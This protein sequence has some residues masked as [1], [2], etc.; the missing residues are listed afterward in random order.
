MATSPDSSGKPSKVPGAG[1][2]ALALVGS[3]L[4]AIYLLNPTAGFL[5]VIPDN[6]PLIGNIDEA[7]VTGLLIYCLSILGVKMPG[8]RG[9]K[10]E[11]MKDVGPGS[12]R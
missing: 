8:M 3:V 12:E 6:V 9:R 2:K 5:E 11:E 7:A 1:A 4:C 10:E